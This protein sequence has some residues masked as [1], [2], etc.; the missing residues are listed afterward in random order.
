MARA[1]V[2]GHMLLHA[3]PDLPAGASVVDKAQYN[4]LFAEER[5]LPGDPVYK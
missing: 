4:S 1:V 3:D 5:H 2:L